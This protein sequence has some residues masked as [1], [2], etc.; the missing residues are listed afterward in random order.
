MTDARAE[1]AGLLQRMKPR[2]GRGDATPLAMWFWDI[3]R[4]LLLIAL[5]LIA[6]GLIAV[7]AASPATAVRYSGGSRHIPSLYYFWRQLGW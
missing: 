2:S 3:D 7:A 4:V 1:R 6:I 5:V